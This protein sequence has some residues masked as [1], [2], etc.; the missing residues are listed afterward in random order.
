M[1]INTLFQL[2]KAGLSKHSI[3]K[4]W[5]LTW[6][7]LASYQGTFLWWYEFCFLYIKVTCFILPLNHTCN[8]SKYHG[9][10]PQSNKHITSINCIKSL[11][12]HVLRAAILLLHIVNFQKGVRA[13]LPMHVKLNKYHREQPQILPLKTNELYV[14]TVILHM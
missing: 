11:K 1:C 3:C 14:M 12:N 5:I 10:T 6:C 7:S 4:T 9:D 13:S 8:I 2:W